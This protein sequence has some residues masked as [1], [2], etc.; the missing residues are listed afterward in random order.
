MAGSIQ[1]T[2]RLY[3]DNGVGGYLPSHTVSKTIV[4]S[5]LDLGDGTQTVTNAAAQ[6]ISVPA[7][8]GGDRYLEIVHLGV[9]SA[10]TASTSYLSVSIDNAGTK[11]VFS[12]IAPSSSILIQPTGAIYATASTATD[13][14]VQIRV[15]DA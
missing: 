8:V 4:Q 11:Y 7:G 10:G 1:T 2:T 6:V 5:G 15:C 9:S 14:M 3:C 12:K 13:V